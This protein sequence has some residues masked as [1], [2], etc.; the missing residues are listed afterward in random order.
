M[1]SRDKLPQQII[2][3]RLRFDIEDENN[4]RNEGDGSFRQ[5]LDLTKW[6]FY[7]VLPRLINSALS[8]NNK[9]SPFFKCAMFPFKCT[10]FL[11]RPSLEC[12][13]LYQPCSHYTS[14]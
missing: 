3:G 8:R 13:R 7:S 1:G 2:Q 12:K 5:G 6:T 11:Y 4:I 9:F 10:I 14:T